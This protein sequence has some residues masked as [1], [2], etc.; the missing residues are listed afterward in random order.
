MTDTVDPN[1][2]HVASR[3]PKTDRTHPSTVEGMRL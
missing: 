1:D 2:G 3:N